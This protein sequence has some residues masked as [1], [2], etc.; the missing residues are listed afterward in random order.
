VLVLAVASKIPYH[1]LSGIRVRSLGSG[2]NKVTYNGKAD[3]I[4]EQL[5]TPTRCRLHTLSIWQAEYPWTTGIS[6]QRPSKHRP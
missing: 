3:D 6:G 2:W 5:T 1:T 4:A